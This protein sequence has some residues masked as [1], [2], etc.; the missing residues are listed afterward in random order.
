MIMNIKRFRNAIITTCAA[1]LLSCLYST[2]LTS[3]EPGRSTTTEK[4][5]KEALERLAKQAQSQQA[6]PPPAAKPQPGLPAASTP[7]TAPGPEAPPVPTPVP[8]GIQRDLSRGM[9]FSFENAELYD[10]INQLSDILGLT[11]ILIDSEIK[12]SVNLQSSAPMPKEDI[13]PLFNLIL[14]NNNAALIKIEGIYQIVPISSA[15]KKGVEIIERL[16]EEPVEGK[17]G[18]EK[19]PAPIS[20]RA[21]DRS[22]GP[23]PAI[24]AGSTPQTLSSA[25]R[26]ATHVIRTEFVPVKDLIEPIKLFM[27]E[28]GVIMP[29]DRLNM[30][31]LTDYTDSAA[32]ILEIIRML[33]NNYLDPNLVE[34]IRIDNNASADVTEDL[35]KIFGSGSKDSAT[36]ISF[37]SLDRLNAIFTMASS[38]RG[39]AEV[40]RWIEI[41]DAASGKKIQ[42]FFY[43]V[44]NAT[45]SSIMETLSALYGGEDTSGSTPPVTEGTATGGIASSGSRSRSGGTFGNSNSGFGSQ[46]QTGSG[47]GM[48]GNQG[49]YGSQAYNA[50]G[51]MGGMGSGSFN[52]GQRLGPQLNARPTMSSQILRGGSFTGLQ[53]TVRLVADDTNNSLV[54]QAMPA[55][56]AYLLETIKKLDILPRQVLIEARIYEVQLN[57]DFKFGVDAWFRPKGS[58]AEPARSKDGSLVGGLL[59]ANTFWFI[60]NSYEMLARLEAIRTKTNLKVLEA[61]SVLA[62]DGT[63][64]SIVVG[65][66]VPYPGGSY[67]PAVGGSTTDIGYRETGVSLIVLPRIS[68]SGF[69]TLEITQ[70]VSAAGKPVTIGNQEA[71]SF[72][73]SRV[74]N[75]FTVKDGET[76]AI[77][78]II[79][80]SNSSSR[81]GI[82]FLSDIPVVG[83]LFGHTGR[84]ADRAELIVMITPR[85]VRTVEKFEEITQELRDSLRNVRKFADEKEQEY[86]QDMENARKDRYEQEK[87]NLNKT[88]PPKPEKPNEPA[89][90]QP[91]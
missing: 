12:G 44:Q 66:E 7:P 43:E 90:P 22:A 89:E 55:D 23:V 27:T 28:G 5:K 24:S 40:K 54:I 83:A 39:L 34:L 64:A 10:V 16:P 80:D 19:K 29:Y 65:S 18:A 47:S 32:R 88:K 33:D 2:P 56:Y 26:L 3:Q 51:N 14:K 71:P 30:L 62:L 8:S 79:R 36:G 60:G 78:G 25:S 68:A 4:E 37:V 46:S 50:G 52:S 15:L 72:L 70:E 57:D 73:L 45:A 42:T 84:L 11:P 31:I 20:P 81:S 63:E 6:A 53:D 69:V 85:V 61:P 38:K 87:R 86:I 49:S 91:K 9:K 76:V 41:L 35:K 77:A 21:K 58:T 74:M 48:F 59:N 13:F 67:T 17:P 82:P 75:T 1:L